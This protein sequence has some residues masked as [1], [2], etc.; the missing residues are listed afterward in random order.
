MLTITMQSALS[1]P[2]VLFADTPVHLTHTALIADES[3]F[4][5]LSPIG[6]QPYRFLSFA[7]SHGLTVGILG[8]IETRVDL[9]YKA[10]SGVKLG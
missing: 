1:S 5:D 2:G 4:K 7:L 8:D 9:L 10:L 6:R 3:A